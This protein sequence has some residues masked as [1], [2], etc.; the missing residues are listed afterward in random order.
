MLQ[1][2]FL[3]FLTPILQLQSLAL[4]EDRRHFCLNSGCPSCSPAEH[5]SGPGPWWSSVQS[6]GSLGRGG[7]YLCRCTSLMLSG[8]M[9]PWDTST[10]LRGVL[11]P[12]QA[13]LSL[14]RPGNSCRAN[15]LQL[16][17]GKLQVFFIHAT[18]SYGTSFE[19]NI[20]HLPVIF[21]CLA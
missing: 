4:N 2:G 3:S 16:R 5:S 21:L 18:A 1:V 17:H 10:L 9:G 20:Q 6:P 7:G 15:T 14:S 8:L 12:E 11:E 19:V 13:G